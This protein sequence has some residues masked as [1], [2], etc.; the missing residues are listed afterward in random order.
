V[1]YFVD[2]YGQTAEGL[3]LPSAI[4]VDQIIAMLSTLPSG[5]TVL[6]CHPG[7]VD[8]LTTMY[9]MERREEVNVLCD[10]RVQAVIR[11]FGIELCSFED[12]NRLKIAPICRQVLKAIWL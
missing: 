1:N 2:F 3:P 4:A 7:D 5:L 8:D 12:W 10:S 6:V 9:Q 11:K